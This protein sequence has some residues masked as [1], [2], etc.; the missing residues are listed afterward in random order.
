MKLYHNY[1]PAVPPSAPRGVQVSAVRIGAGLFGAPLAFQTHAFLSETLLAAYL[2]SPNQSLPAA[3]IWEALIPIILAAISI[4]CLTV[5]LRSGFIAWS[6]WW[7][8]ETHP[9]GENK[10]V[11]VMSG[12]RIRFLLIGISIMSSLIFTSVLICNIYRLLLAP[13]CIS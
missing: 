8:I 12:S 10:T 13:P 2:C 3:T 6:S 1:D 5:A 7:R 9:T 4:I 11:M